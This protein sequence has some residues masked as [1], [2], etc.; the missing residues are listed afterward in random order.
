MAL[1]EYIRC[2]W[3]VVAL[4]D[5]C[6]PVDYWVR[7]QDFNSERQGLRSVSGWWIKANNTENGNRILVETK[8]GLLTRL[9]AVRDDAAK[10][11][12]D[13]RRLL[14]ERRRM[15]D[16]LTMILRD[17]DKARLER[18]RKPILESEISHL[19]AERNRLRERLETC[20][21]ENNSLLRDLISRRRCRSS[22]SSRK[23]SPKRR[24]RSDGGR[25]S[26]EGW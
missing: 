19:C 15:L 11:L 4:H 8:K 21:R 26:G 9:E 20:K 10:I 23:P 12:Y 16:D 1:H 3:R 14:D 24:R 18:G 13:N 22:S 7:K 5:I 2:P 6:Q 17:L 25:P